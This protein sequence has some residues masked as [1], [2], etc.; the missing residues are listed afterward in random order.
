MKFLYSVIKG[1]KN[2]GLV[3]AEPSRFKVRMK[4][5]WQDLCEDP[6]N[7]GTYVKY[8]ENELHKGVATRQ[9]WS[10]YQ[11]KSKHVRLRHPML[12]EAESIDKALDTL[13]T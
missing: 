12:V 7:V 13:L 8:L 1:K 9:L 3:V 10:L 2:L 11:N 6:E 4:K 5:D